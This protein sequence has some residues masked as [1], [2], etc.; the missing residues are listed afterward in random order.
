[1]LM[2]AVTAQPP[3]LPANPGWRAPTVA[4]QYRHKIFDRI[5]QSEDA[6]RMRTWQ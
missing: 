5:L 3:C 2:F 1:V 6:G 4:G